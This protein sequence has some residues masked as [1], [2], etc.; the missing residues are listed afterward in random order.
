MSHARFFYKLDL[1]RPSGR[2]HPAPRSPH[3]AGTIY[4]WPSLSALLTATGLYQEL[5][6]AGEAR[7]PAQQSRLNLV[8]A[9]T[10]TVNGFSGVLLGPF[11][12][13]AGPRACSVVSHAIVAAGLLLCAFTSSALDLF[14]VG[15]V[16]VGLGGPGVQMACFH[17]SNL[18]GSSKSTATAFIS[19]SFQLGFSVF[20]FFSLLHTEG[21]SVRA[22]FIGYA[23]VVLVQLLAGLLIWPDR[24]FAMGDSVDG[25]TFV[26]A[27]SRAAMADEAAAD[28]AEALEAAVQPRVGDDGASGP[29]L[30]DDPLLQPLAPPAAAIPVGRFRHPSV[31]VKSPRAA[32]REWRLENAGAASE[33]RRGSSS[34]APEPTLVDAP[35]LRQL[36]SPIMLHIAAY[37]CVTSFCFN[38][39]L[40]N[41]GQQ[42]ERLGCH[43][44]GGNNGS[45]AWNATL[46]PAASSA[47]PSCDS[48]LQALQ[49]IMSAS[50]L[51]MPIVGWLLDRRGFAYSLAVTIAATVVWAA[52]LLV[53][54]LWFQLVGFAAYAFARTLLYAFVF[55][56]I[57]AFFGFRYFG[58]LS[59]L[60]LAAGGAV[61]L[62]QAPLGNYVQDSMGGDFRDVNIAQLALSVAFLY[63]PLRMRRW[64]AAL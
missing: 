13:R 2:A 53:P 32:R 18:F 24:A 63:L 25:E 52:V 61:A 26:G 42:L 12:D 20:L 34:A 45:S 40:A 22:L 8:F 39:F 5:C 58:L 6:S 19:G 60:L 44:A 1:W 56:F 41:A 43:A 15:F 28:A 55:A 35:V 33:G 27:L 50:V 7:C 4:G 49:V 64:E 47:A 30:A 9:V 46:A 29:S 11:L 51:A 48:F 37:F 38:F 36:T 21:A 14:F 17:I 59:G 62:L 16:L 10:V 31:L 54:H 57:G 23:S 3:A